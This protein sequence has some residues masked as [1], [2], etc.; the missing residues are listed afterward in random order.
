MRT[1]ASSPWASHTRRPRVSRSVAAAGLVGIL[2]LV[3]ASGPAAEQRRYTVA[4][5]NFTEEPGVTLEGTGFTGRDVRESFRLAA[6]GHPLD[7]IFYDNQRDGRKALANVEAVIGRRVNLYI[8]YFRD[9]AVNAIVAEK[10]R[11]ANIPVLAVNYPVPGAP[12]YTADNAASGRIAGE[13]LAQFAVTTWRTEPTVG[14]LLGDLTAVADRVPE[15]AK[16]VQEGLKTYLPKLGVTALDTQGNPVR[17]ASLVR[18][19]L[20]G[21]PAT[22][23]LIATMD[24]AT[25]LAAKDTLER[26]GRLAD[27]AIVSHGV[28]RSIHGGMSERKEIDPSNRGSIVIGSVA[29]YVDRYGYDVLPLALRMLRGES[30]PPRTVTRHRLIT[31]TNVFAEYPPYDMQ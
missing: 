21:H 25:A 30:V 14:V 16:G 31:A 4:F 5:A 24:D 27:G 10:L 23:I 28:D 22:K 13:T 1:A 29:Y 6:R 15:R 11:A 8:Q 19:F 20:A 3:S 7:L 12:L 17:V 18:K 26:A 9:P 2:L